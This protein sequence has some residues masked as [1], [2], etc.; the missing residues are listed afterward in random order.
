MKSAIL[1]KIT[2]I[3]A[4][5]L[6]FCGMI[7]GLFVGLITLPPSERDFLKKE[8]SGKKLLKNRG[9]PVEK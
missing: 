7:A 9:K 4:G 6:T 8:R 2:K 3:P 5:L 1:S